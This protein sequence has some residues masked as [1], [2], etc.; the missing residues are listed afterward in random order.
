MLGF[1]AAEYKHVVF[2]AFK[3]R[4]LLRDGRWCICKEVDD[5]VK[6]V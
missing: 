3:L 2:F 1:K 4:A 6:N 5:F